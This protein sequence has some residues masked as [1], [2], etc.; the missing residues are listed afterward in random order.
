MLSHL[1]ANLWL[2][3]LT[4]LLCSVLYPALLLGIGQ[5]IFPDQAQGSL[6]INAQGK[7]IG[8][9]LIGQPFTGDEYF[10]PRPS[11]TTP[12]YNAAA[13]GASNWGANNPLLRDRVARTLGTVVRYKDAPAGTRTVQEDIVDWFKSLP[14]LVAEWAAARPTSAQAWVNADDKHKAAVADWQKAHPE[15]VAA[16]QKDNPG[17]GEPKPADLAVPFFKANAA[18][19]HKAWPK[20]IDDATW[21]VEAVFFDLWRTA[22]PDVA[23]EEVPADMVTASGSG[24]DPHITLANAHYQLKYRV[25][26]AQ[27]QKLLK[28][29]NP[30]ADDA[31]K[32]RVETKVR[33][34]IESVL[35]ERKEAPLGGLVGVDLVNVLEVNLA[36]A[37][38]MEKLAREIR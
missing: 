38:R 15:A 31:E 24:L 25:A 6:V 1:R 9:R 20:L 19:F 13:S 5:T 7:V 11:A 29:R 34:V 23:L 18:A 36:V 26:A 2:V 17:S 4:L 33:D 8:S 3:L 12:S 22:H 16:W 35:Q 30:P 28:D 27:A 21:S 32:K 10:W 14:D 37:D